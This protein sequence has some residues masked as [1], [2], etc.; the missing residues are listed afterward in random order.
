MIDESLQ[1]TIYEMLDYRINAYRLKRFG[2]RLLL[3]WRKK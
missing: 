3:I 1:S 2:L